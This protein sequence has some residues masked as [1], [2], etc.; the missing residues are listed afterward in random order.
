MST[1]VYTAYRLKKSS[2]LWSFVRSANATA[3]K[4]VQERIREIHSD[5]MKTA[6]SESVDFGDLVERYQDEGKA[7]SRI[8]SD[9]LLKGYGEQL[10]SSHRN[11]FDFNVSIAIWE[12]KKGLY[13]RPFCDMRMRDVLDFL[14]RDRRLQDF[15]FWDN[16]DRPK[17]I[18]E[19][20]WK[21]RGRVWDAIDEDRTN[22]NTNCLVL[23]ICSWTNFYF[24]LPQ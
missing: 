5:L 22:G 18:T 8:A 13:I 7:R 6:P 4:N 21:A 1:K 19:K 16:T 15:S 10:S 24:L 12:H 14:K 17:R 9:A 3:M 11:D 20:Q 2:D 23:D